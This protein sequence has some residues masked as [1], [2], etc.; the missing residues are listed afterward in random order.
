[1]S[2]I[3]VIIVRLHGTR[4]KSPTYSSVGSCAVMFVLPLSKNK[5][6]VPTIGMSTQRSSSRGIKQLF[7]WF[8]MRGKKLITIKLFNSMWKTLCQVDQK[9]LKMFLK[10]LFLG[11]FS[12]NILNSNSLGNSMDMELQSQSTTFNFH[13]QTS[14]IKQLA[15]LSR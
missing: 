9:L 7:S 5:N 8:K 6:T 14:K 4:Q 2:F 12:R 13:T 3:N 10:V 11:I 15:T 1:M